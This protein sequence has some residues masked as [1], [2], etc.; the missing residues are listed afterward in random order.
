MTEGFI[1]RLFAASLDAQTG[2][3][4]QTERTLAP[5]TFSLPL[6]T[7]SGRGK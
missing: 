5:N 3:V 1:F 4:L 2:D 7:A 6:S